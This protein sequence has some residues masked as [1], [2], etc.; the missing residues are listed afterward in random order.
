M[1]KRISKKPQKLKNSPKT[2]FRNFK[3]IHETQGRYCW[4]FTKTKN[5][6]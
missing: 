5:N 2:K 6:V 3:I 4:G 1:S